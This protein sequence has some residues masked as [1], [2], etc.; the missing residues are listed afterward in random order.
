MKLQGKYVIEHEPI[1]LD[2]NNDKLRIILVDINFHIAGLDTPFQ[3]C[4]ITVNDL[5][6]MLNLNQHARILYTVDL[7]SEIPG[8]SMYV[9][10]FPTEV[11][12]DIFG[13]NNLD[14]DNEL[15]LKLSESANYFVNE[16]IPKKNYIITV[17]KID[18]ASCK[19]VVYPVCAVTAN[20]LSMITNKY[21]KLLRDDDP[22]AYIKDTI[23][24]IYK[25]EPAAIGVR[26]QVQ[27]TMMIADKFELEYDDIQAGLQIF[28]FAAANHPANLFFKSFT[29]SLFNLHLLPPLYL[30]NKDLISPKY[31]DI[32]KTYLDPIK[33]FVTQDVS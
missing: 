29:S 8:R 10:A 5:E 30:N 18:N 3:E 25:N 20:E 23:I 19:S 27:A 15:Y 22:V 2:H 4:G 6:Y 11:F 9:T 21:Q 17:V 33:N 31:G 24:P 14:L 7:S 1:G 12:L 16:I 32:V 28:K 13:N 26:A